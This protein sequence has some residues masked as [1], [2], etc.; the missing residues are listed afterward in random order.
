MTYNVFG[1]T[2]NLAQSIN[3]STRHFSRPTESY[4]TQRPI[5]TADYSPRA[6]ESAPHASPYL[7][8]GCEGGV[9]TSHVARARYVPLV[10]P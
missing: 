10:T 8:A 2:L 9:M 6:S 4:L 1:E 7:I 3:P 5:T